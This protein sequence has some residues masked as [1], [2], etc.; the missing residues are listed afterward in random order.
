MDS[1][2]G[3]VIGN[4]TRDVVMG[5]YSMGE[6]L[7]TVPD[8]LASGLCLVYAMLLGLGVK[9]S[10]TVNSFLTIINLMVMGLVVVLGIY[11]A[12]IT[13]WSS[14]NGGLLPYGFG[15]V[16]TGKYPSFV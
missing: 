15:G 2:I 12:D 9:F 4:Y 16:I 7:G 13:N 11:Y 14:Q 8:F 10:T 3:G 5:G 1:L 6:P